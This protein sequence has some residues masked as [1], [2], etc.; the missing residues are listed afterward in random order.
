MAEFNVV[1]REDR[2][3]MIQNAMLDSRTYMVSLSHWGF[4]TILHGEGNLTNVFHKDYKG[5]TRR[6]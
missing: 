5:S 3:M 6:E 2:I 4:N 1:W